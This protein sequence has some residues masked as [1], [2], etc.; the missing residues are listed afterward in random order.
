MQI[1]G[2][3]VFTFSQ[4]KLEVGNN[5]FILIQ[6]PVFQ[7]SEK[8][9]Q[10]HHLAHVR[11]HVSGPVSLLTLALY[12]IYF[13]FLGHIPVVQLNYTVLS[14][15]SPFDRDLVERCV[16]EVLQ[17][18]SKSVQK[19]SNVEIT[20]SGIGRL[21]VRNSKAKMRFFKEFITSM[22][23]SG[24]LMNAFMVSQVIMM[25][26]LKVVH[27]RKVEILFRNDERQVQRYLLL[28]EIPQDLLLLQQQRSQSE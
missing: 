21:N 25:T 27:T 18:V 1:P 20:F 6:R 3:G 11:H 14:M 17:A 24:N 15:E 26:E 5:K 7:L 12:Y 10:T 19:N 13:T 2:L 9:A 16:K 23:K 28:L 8:F 22:D 4:T